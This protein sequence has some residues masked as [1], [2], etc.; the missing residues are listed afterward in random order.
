MQ[1]LPQLVGNNFRS[2]AE[3]ERFKLLGLGD[4]LTLKRDPNNEYDRNAIRVIQTIDDEEYFL[5]FIDRENAAN[6]APILDAEGGT[7]AEG[8]DPEVLQCEVHSLANPKKPTLL[9]EVTTGW[10]VP[11]RVQEPGEEEETWSEG[12]A[13]G[14]EDEDTTE[15]D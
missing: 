9:V 10:E 12:F 7:V 14:I 13:E 1:F 5:G 2:A 6:L 11:T 8:H 4:K 3:R 15:G